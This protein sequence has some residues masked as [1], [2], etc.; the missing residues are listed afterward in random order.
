M[1]R[2][3]RVDVTDDHASAQHCYDTFYYFESLPLYLHI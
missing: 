1:I 3:R 2:E